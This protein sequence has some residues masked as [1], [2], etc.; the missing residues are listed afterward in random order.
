MIAADIVKSLGGRQNGEG[1]MCRCPAHDDRTPSLSVS[2]AEDG[3]V[4]FYCFAGCS[5]AEVMDALTRQGLWNGSGAAM[6]HVGLKHKINRRSTKP[7]STPKLPDNR[8]TALNIWR[9]TQPFGG[10]LAERYLIERGI[11]PPDPSPLRFY[12]ALDYFD[13]G[14]PGGLS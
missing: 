2:E 7:R 8:R 9:A 4:L 6:R 14:A 3:T 1:Y 11:V 10:T 12:P 5:Q 13:N